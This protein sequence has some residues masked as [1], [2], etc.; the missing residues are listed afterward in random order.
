[1]ITREAVNKNWRPVGFWGTTL[2]L[3][4]CLAALSIGVFVGG[5]I[6]DRALE[7]IPYIG[8]LWVGLAGIREGGKV[9]RGEA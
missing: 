7:N 6:Y 1:M 9:M 8:T 3:V 2:A 4:F 5:G